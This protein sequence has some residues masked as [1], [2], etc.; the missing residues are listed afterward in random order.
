MKEAYP[1]PA[2]A[3]QTTSNPMPFDDPSHIPKNNRSAQSFVGDAIYETLKIQSTQH[4]EEILVPRW[5]QIPVGLF[6]GAITLLLLAGSAL[7]VFDQNEKAPI[8]A[9]IIGVIWIIG[10]FWVLAWFLLVLPIGRVFTGYFKSHTL[11]A[12][13]QTTAYVCVF[14]RLRLLAARRDADRASANHSSGHA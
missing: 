1:H 2:L 3:D 10:C 13:A 12:V 9:P 11:I 4:A 8:L 6:L 14:V 5:I 7:M